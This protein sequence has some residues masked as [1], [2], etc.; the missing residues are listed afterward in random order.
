MKKSMT[1]KD[2]ARELSQRINISQSKALRAVLEVFQIIEGCLKNDG[3][4]VISRFGT[5]MLKERKPRTGRNPH[6]REAV[7]IPARKIPCLKF[8]ANVK[9]VL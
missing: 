9:K 8:S 7:P 5:F 4:V 3:R 1:K 6:T 2:L